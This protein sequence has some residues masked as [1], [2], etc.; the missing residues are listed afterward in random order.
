MQGES[1]HYVEPVWALAHQDLSL[2]PKPMR[3]ADLE[4]EPCPESAARSETH[5]HAGN[6]TGREALSEGTHLRIQ[7]LLNVLSHH[8]DLL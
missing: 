1:K 7:Q 5:T 3:G 2:G 8:I 6:K 4:E